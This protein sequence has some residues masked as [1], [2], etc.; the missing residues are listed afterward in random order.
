M[1][2]IRRLYRVEDYGEA[3]ERDNAVWMFLEKLVLIDGV[4]A[5]KVIALDDLQPGHEAVGYF[6]TGM[7]AN[8]ARIR[9]LV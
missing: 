1:S 4:A 3:I 2:E 5:Q 9:R 6:R 7:A 8:T